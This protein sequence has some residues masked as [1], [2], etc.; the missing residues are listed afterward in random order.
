MGGW[1]Y[2]A[3]KK[4]F[5]GNLNWTSPPATRKYGEQSVAPYN[6]HYAYITDAMAGGGVGHSAIS[7]FTYYTPYSGYKIQKNLEY[8]G[9]INDNSPTGYSQWN[10]DLGKY[11]TK[12][13][14]Y[15]K[16]TQTAI[17]VMTLL[18]YYD[19]YKTMETFIYPALYSNYGSYFS[20][21]TLNA[22]ETDN[23]CRLEVRNNDNTLY[24]FNLKSSKLTDNRMN[25]FQVNLPLS[26]GPYTTAKI[27]CSN[28]ELDHR[29]IAPL[30]F[31]L[32]DPIVVG[33]KN[34]FAQALSQ[35]RTFAERYKPNQ[36]K[37]KGEFLKT[38]NNDFAPA[39][40]YTD[41]SVVHTGESYYVNDSYYIALSNDASSPNEESTQWRYLG[42]ASTYI[43]SGDNDE[44]TLEIG[45]ISQNF[46]EVYDKSMY[47]YVPAQDNAVKTSDTVPGWWRLGQNTIVVIGIDTVTGR[48]ENITLLAKCGYF[49]ID[50]GRTLSDSSA[51]YFYY[52]KKANAS[53]PKGI[54][55]ISFDMYGTSWHDRSKEIR[56]RVKGTF[57][58]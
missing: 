34:G 44:F 10:K 26:E 38:F 40:K 37:S 45:T 42:D 47:F 28:S 21:S 43:Q 36:F 53:I 30:D 32:K 52:D 7:K 41:S 51:L 58:K 9:I 24:S 29:E 55:D 17:P 12:T 49:K 57:R 50:S 14:N 13:V 35:M 4:R 3:Y 56:V 22:V 2:D 33:Q 31:D 15:P 39:Q 20:P 54:Y 16:P 5:L 46:T 25:Q 6:N 1:S 11:E 19:P 23:T 27:I 18:G 8:A 48:K